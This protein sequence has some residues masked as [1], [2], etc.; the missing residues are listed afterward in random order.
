M[1]RMYTVS[2]K[3]S[4]LTTAKTLLLL[5]VPIGT[6]TTLV[7]ASITNQS[8]LT[9]QQLEACWQRVTTIGSAAGTAATPAKHESGDAAA[10]TTVLVNLTTEPT[11]YTA[12]TQLG[13]E[14]LPSLSGW[15]FPLTPRPFWALPKAGGAALSYLGLRLLVA[16][17]SFDAL[18][19][20]TFVEEG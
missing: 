17:T 10:A 7:S 8:N 13:Y 6:M 5:T 20:C 16:P 11:T 4:T 19:Q 1:P 9:N 14:A 12:S 3:I 15:I 2:A 18:V